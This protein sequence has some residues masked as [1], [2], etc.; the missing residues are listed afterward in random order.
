ML[1]LSIIGGIRQQQPLDV[2]LQKR[3]SPDSPEVRL[4]A[5]PQSYNQIGKSAARF[6]GQ[7]RFAPS[8]GITTPTRTVNTVIALINRARPTHA[9]GDSAGGKYTR[10]AALSLLFLRHSRIAET[11]RVIHCTQSASH[12]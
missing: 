5:K 7:K 10:T 4:S 12:E 3:R 2:V 9:S 8:S 6:V 1:Q 11:V